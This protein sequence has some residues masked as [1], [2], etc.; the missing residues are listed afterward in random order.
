MNA[1]WNLPGPHYQA[2]LGLLRAAEALWDGSRVFFD[3]WKLSPSQFNILN[4]LVEHPDGISQA[5]LGRQ[6]I[7]RRS[8]VTGLLDRME[9]RKLLQRKETLGDRRAHRVILTDRGRRLLSEILPHYHQAA[10]E[11]WGDI[12][13]S[14]A[15]QIKDS[16]DEL[17]KTVAQIAHRNTRGDDL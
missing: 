2:T 1:N 10:E 11:I 6:L 16:L 8:N 15:N 13:A 4:L 17:S 7:M 12:S 5:D 14:Q 3:R 9:K